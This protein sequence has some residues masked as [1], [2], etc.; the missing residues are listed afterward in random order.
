MAERIRTCSVPQ[1]RVADRRINQT[2]DTLAKVVEGEGLNDMI[3]SVIA[4]DQAARLASVEDG[5]A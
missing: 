5:F 1:G 4:E 3:G 2:L